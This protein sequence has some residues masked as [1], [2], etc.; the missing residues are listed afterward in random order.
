MVK[1]INFLH[2]ILVIFSFKQL[3]KPT[4]LLDDI[5]TKESSSPKY[6][7]NNATAKGIAFRHYFNYVLAFWAHG[8]FNRD[9]NL[10]LQFNKSMAKNGG[11]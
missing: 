8:Y 1:K 9:Q 5:T 7:S 4:K 10:I 11:K 3:Y 6:C 2:N